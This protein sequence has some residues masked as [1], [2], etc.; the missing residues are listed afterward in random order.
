MT[1]PLPDAF[2]EYGDMLSSPIG[3]AALTNDDI[4]GIDKGPFEVLVGLL[5]EPSVAGL[6]AA[7]FDGWNSSG[8]ASEMSRRRKAIHAAHLTFDHDRQ[9]VGHAG[10]GF[11]Q[12]NVGS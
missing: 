6:A 9:D 2:L 10:K 12:L 3:M 1:F 7:G 8:I 4:G 11:E 5:S